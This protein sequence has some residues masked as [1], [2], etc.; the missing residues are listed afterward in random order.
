MPGT[1]ISKEIHDKSFIGD[2]TTDEYY[3]DDGGDS[4]SVE[5]TDLPGFAVAFSGADVIY[6]HAKG[7][8]RKSTLSKSIS[9]SDV[10]LSGVKGKQL[11]YDTPTKPDR[12]EM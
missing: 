4:Y 1:P 8:L 2:I 12:P 6:D 9:F 11:I 5:I 3:V 7:A 10:T